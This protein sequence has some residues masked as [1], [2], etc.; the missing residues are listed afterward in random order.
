L[1]ARHP[2]D[3]HPAAEPDQHAHEPRSERQAERGDAVAVG[4]VAL[5]GGVERLGDRRRSSAE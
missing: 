4:D 3:L 5:A 2:L 1:P